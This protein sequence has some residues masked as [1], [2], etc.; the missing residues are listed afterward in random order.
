M[1]E[2]STFVALEKAMQE[3]QIKSIRI[4][5]TTELVAVEISCKDISEPS[6]ATA[7]L[8][9]KNSVRHVVA[10]ALDQIG[11]HTSDAEDAK[12]KV[13]PMFGPIPF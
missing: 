9:Q 11:I 13:L 10:A 12:G 8:S 4:G 7:K 6:S 1:E 2:I 5:T 3:G